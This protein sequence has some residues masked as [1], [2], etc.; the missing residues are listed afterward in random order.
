MINRQRKISS[1]CMVN[2][3]TGVARR[4]GTVL[5]LVMTVL[6]LLFVTGVALMATMSFESELIAVAKEHAETR[7]VIDDVAA[8][9]DEFL[10]TGMG[11]VI[12]ATTGATFIDQPGT[13]METLSSMPFAQAPGRFNSFSP[14]EPYVD[15]PTLGPVK[16]L[17]ES[18]FPAALRI[19]IELVDDQKRLDRPT[20]HVM[21]IPVGG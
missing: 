3:K 8:T 18:V 19:T 15:D 12:D 7:P 11:E 2:G 10:A 21:I 16:P 1:A 17:P 6:G 9:I 14:I 5:I 20:R 13:A 4:R